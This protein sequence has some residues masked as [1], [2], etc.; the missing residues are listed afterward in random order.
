MMHLLLFIHAN[1]YVIFYI[2]FDTH[3]IFAP[4]INK[5]KIKLIYGIFFLTIKFYHQID[6]Y[7]Q[8]ITLNSLSVN[9][10]LLSKIIIDDI[11]YDKIEDVL[12]NYCV[13]YH[14][15]ESTHWELFSGHY[16]RLLNNQIYSNNQPISGQY[17]HICA[18]IPL[19]LR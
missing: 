3:H 15:S 11:I 9:Y 18:R 5:I 14:R 10:Y 6:E 8:V 7:L 4:L 17:Q 13:S 16:H 1:L 19:L 2:D 12:N